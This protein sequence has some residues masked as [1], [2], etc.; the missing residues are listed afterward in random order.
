MAQ[1]EKRNG[2]LTGWWY[3]EVDN[4]HKG[5]V[6]FRRRFETK[7][8]AQAYEAYVRACGEEPPGATEGEVNARTFASVAAEC[9]EAGGPKGAWKRRRDPSVLTRLATLTRMPLG[10]L[11]RQGVL[12]RPHGRCDGP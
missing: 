12:Q 4:R 8:K 11:D 10:K 9:K 7:A 2:K 5:G 3:G 1:A 6:R